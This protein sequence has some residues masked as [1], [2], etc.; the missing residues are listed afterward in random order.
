MLSHRNE[1][2]GNKYEAVEYASFTV[3]TPYMVGFFHSC[4][5]V[6]CRLYEGFPLCFFCWVPV[7]L[8]KIYD[9]KS[10]N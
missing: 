3:Y 5:S 2:R 8:K 4:D 1:V 6:G 9:V 7:N 10:H